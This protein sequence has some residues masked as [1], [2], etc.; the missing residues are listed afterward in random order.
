MTGQGITLLGLGPGNPQALTREAWEWLAQLDEIYL[1]T[2]YHP[3][4][5]ALPTHIQRI[6]FDQVYEENVLLEEVFEKI[7]ATIL[8]LGQRP[9]GVTY[10]VPGHPFVA[11]ETCPEIYRRAK[12]MGLPVRVIEGLS[13]LEPTFRALEMDPFP[14]TTIVDAF[15]LIQRQVPS[16]PCSQ[17]ALIGQ[18]YSRAV[19]SDVKLTLMANYPDEHGVI[20]VHAA[21]TTEERIESMPLHAIDQSPHL[22]PL[23]SLYLPPLPNGTAFEDFQEIIARLRAPDGCPWDCEQTHASLKPFL[24]EEAYEALEALDNEDMD[25]LRE[26]LGDVLLQI[27]LH[28][29]IGTEYGDFK[30]ADVLRGISDKLIRRHPHV[31]ADVNVSD[32]DGVIH[33]WEMIKAGERKGNGKPEKKGMLDGIPAALPALSQAQAIQSRAKRIG[34]DWPEIDGVIRK[35]YEELDELKAAQDAEARI[36]ESGDLLFAAVNVIRWLGVD[37]ESA[38]RGC[39]KRFR[40]RFAYIEQAA[41]A[42]GTD[43]DSMSFEE[44]DALWEE[45]KRKFK[46]DLQSGS[47]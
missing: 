35:V 43:L 20:L 27:V 41:E 32:V 10:G 4:V 11:E 25:A 14:E 3:C 44:M 12:Q 18:I 6:S 33:N 42:R 24:L 40:R 29:Q 36:A 39:N 1:R 30:M 22:G 16:F 23:S 8:E 38:L 7:I 21:G 28:A 47:R 31:F 15:K 26:E 13:F 45:A 17:P 34:F 46:A 37:A 5:P 2:A 9:Q 19:A